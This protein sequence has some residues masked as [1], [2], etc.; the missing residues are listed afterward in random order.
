MFD[1]DTLKLHADLRE[2]SSRNS[3]NRGTYPYDDVL[4]AGNHIKLWAPKDIQ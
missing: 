2:Y 4:Q 3:L 1:V